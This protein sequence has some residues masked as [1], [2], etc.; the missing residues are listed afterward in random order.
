MRRIH[1]D[2]VTEGMVLARAIYSVDGNILL[3][4]GIK[5]KSS[6]VE[7]FKSIGI[8]QVYV[9]DEISKD[10]EI[11][12]VISDETRFEAR[13]AI[14]NAMNNIKYTNALEVGPVKAVVSKIIEELMSI[15]DA[16]IN[17]QD[18]KDSDNYT[19][20][21]SANV[22]VLSVITGIALG[23][24]KEKLKNLA[25]GAIMHDV[26]KTKIPY[27]I[28]NKPGKLTEEE[29]EEMQKHPRYGYEI[30]KKSIELSTY[31]SYIALTHHERYDG[32]GYPL[33]L[34]EDKIHEF[35]KIVSI[36]DVYDAMT[37]DRVYRKRYKINEAVE[38]IIGMGHH[39]FDYKIVRKFVEHIAIFPSGSTVELNSGEQA[40]VVDIN[41][42]YPNRPIVRLIKD[43][44]GNEVVDIIEIDLTKHNTV[45]IVDI[46]EDL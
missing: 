11:S 4:A 37:S 34:K 10:I 38:Y 40:I 35:S 3:N 29:Y 31:A 26:G 33:G 43:R 16:I 44:E 2:K 5:L 14:K 42:K 21:H 7:K 28:L 23:Y 13:I 1:V 17:L 32:K 20:Y 15:Q 36:A 30:L 45:I 39:Q 9:E 18:L 22:C 8:I 41:K 46:I 19:F 25:L 12:D 24:D 6:Y 27:E